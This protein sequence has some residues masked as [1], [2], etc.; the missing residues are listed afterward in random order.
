MSTVSLSA[1]RSARIRRPAP[2][3]I[4]LNRESFRPVRARRRSRTHAHDQRRGAAGSAPTSNVTSSR[5]GPQAAGRASTQHAPRQDA[6]APP[7]NQQAQAKKDA[8]EREHKA[9]E[10]RIGPSRSASKKRSAAMPP[11]TRRRAPAPNEARARRAGREGGAVLIRSPRKDPSKAQEGANGQ[12]PA[13]GDHT[14][15]VA[16]GMTGRRRKKARRRDR[17][18][19]PRPPSTCSNAPTAPVVRDVRIGQTVRVGELAS[20]MAVK[21]AGGVSRS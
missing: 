3:Q 20:R 11:P 19:R 5:A 7:V 1:R 6:R 16:D 13:D 17:P 21:G 9:A 2:R 10:R 12:E 8:E 4:T 14:L 15:H 18:S